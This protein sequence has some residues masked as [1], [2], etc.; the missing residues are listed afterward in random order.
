MPPRTIIRE[1]PMEVVI[2]KEVIV[3]K[4]IYAPPITMLKEIPTE[5]VI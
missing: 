5:V 4:I 1:L 2:E 3:E